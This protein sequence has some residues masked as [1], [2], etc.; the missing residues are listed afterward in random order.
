M[1]IRNFEKEPMTQLEF[2]EG[3]LN[4]TNNFEKWFTENK[5][6][7]FLDCLDSLRSCI[8]SA[9]ELEKKK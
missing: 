3:A 2:L 7:F 9:I 8:N 4:W 1:K 5:E 6:F